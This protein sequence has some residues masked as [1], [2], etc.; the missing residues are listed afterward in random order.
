MEGVRG[1]KYIGHTGQV[2]HVGNLHMSGVRMRDVQY[3]GHIALPPIQHCS[4]RFATMSSMHVT[5]ITF[6]T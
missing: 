3:I 2:L 5:H 4:S 1:I 6:S